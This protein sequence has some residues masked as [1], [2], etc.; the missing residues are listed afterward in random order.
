MSSTP[1][2]DVTVSR[3]FSIPMNTTAP[4][5]FALGP[6]NM[7]LTRDVDGRVYVFVLYKWS[8]ALPPFYNRFAQARPASLAAFGG[9]LCSCRYLT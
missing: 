4:F 7:I 1:A 6:G 8:Y 9:S 3:A 2:S 5:W